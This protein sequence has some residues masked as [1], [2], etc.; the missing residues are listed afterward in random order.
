[1]ADNCQDEQARVD[2]A[3]E[4]LEA[5]KR[6]PA[7]D[8]GTVGNLTS[9]EFA[10]A[11]ELDGLEV[12][13]QGHRER[14]EPVPADITARMEE[15]RV[16]LVD[17]RAKL[18][19]WQP[20]LGERAN[21]IRQAQNVLTECL[22]RANRGSRPKITIRCSISWKHTAPGRY[23]SNIPATFYSLELTL[24]VGSDQPEE[25]RPLP[26]PPELGR[27]DGVET[28]AGVDFA[29]GITAKLGRH[30]WTRPGKALGRRSHFGC[31]G[32]ATFEID[33]IQLPD[34]TEDELRR[35][36]ESHVTFCDPFKH[37]LELQ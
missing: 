19:P 26:L 4:A 1:M 16:E 37:E 22:Q 11:S 14:A 32:S 36:A 30:Q 5:T 29:P 35:V 28:D 12:K 34:M 8:G 27:E 25:S 21:A 9:E 33:L 15:V 20:E 3:I 17:V 10:L 31:Y 24:V 18:S 7:G 13:D 2:A 23:D 6:K